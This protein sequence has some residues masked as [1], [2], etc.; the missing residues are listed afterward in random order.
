MQTKDVLKMVAIADITVSATNPRK[1]F[2]EDA[3][4][5]L[6]KSVAQY[7]V[8]TPILLRPLGKA[9]ELVCGER[10]YR[11]S[12]MAGKTQIPANIR[13]L[14][15]DEAFELQIIENL[16]RKEV[17]PL[18]E[19]EAFRRMLDSG[20]YQ[21]ADI[22]AKLAKPETFVAQRLKLNDLI[23][24]IKK[25][26]F[27]GELTI[28]QAVL[29]ARMES[30][31]Q[32]EVYD[33]YKD[34]GSVDGYG[35]MKQLIAEISNTK[36]EISKAKFSTAGIY[37]DILPCTQCPK[38]TSNNA[39]LFPDMQ[40]EDSCMDK[41][42]FRR[43]TDLY[44][45]EKMIIHNTQE[46]RTFFGKARNIKLSDKVKLVAD[47]YGITVL[48]EYKDIFHE[49]TG[50]EKIQVLYLTAP[51]EGELVTKYLKK[52]VVPAGTTDPPPGPGG[53]P[54]EPYTEKQRLTDREKRMVELD[55]Q[56]VH[57]T[58]VEQLQDKYNGSLVLLL[59]LEPS[60][61]NA[62]FIYM[63]LNNNEIY[64]LSKDIEALGIKINFD[65]LEGFLE[66]AS[67]WG[68]DEKK[69][70]CALVLFRRCK[71]STDDKGMF[72]QIIRHLANA[73]PFI[74]VDAIQNDQDKVAAERKKRFDEKIAELEK[75]QG[76]NNKSKKK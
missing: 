47:D 57:L 25:D 70:I 17:H 72:G 48:E 45:M 23:E 38:R 62:M 7:G 37:G 31:A 8:M 41:W 51:A 26:F 5:E 65:S 22:A 50:G 12:V 40:G 19:A 30:V 20:R 54:L 66:C 16:E 33:D 43:K 27:N 32:Q 58:I 53:A 69:M 6:S 2:D 1:H 46:G 75:A 11:A 73:H 52:E 15:D 42:C 28:S 44:V 24:P 39:T 60:F 64:Y 76:I 29:I 74:D 4:K 67:K 55:R 21:M 18:D 49:N 36:M 56:K 68:P 13:N 61:I 59:E 9:Y 14:S 34:C 35:T 71:G 10:R 3:L 63:A